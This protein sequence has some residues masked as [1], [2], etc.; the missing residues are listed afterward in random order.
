MQPNDTIRCSFCSKL[1]AD[2]DK[3]IE[4]PG[5]YICNECVQLCVEILDA[6]VSENAQLPAR[7]SLD[8]AALMARL[9]RIAAVAD[10]VEAALDRWVGEARRRGV[11]WARIGES[12]GM[13]RQS[14]W[15][16][17]SDA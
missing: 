13:T 14:A 17:F 7:E 2:V 8:D 5:T 10:Q 6:G 3:I 9:P 1:A 4:G 15:K 12:L 11:P 16:R